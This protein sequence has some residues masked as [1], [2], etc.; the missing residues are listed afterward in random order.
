M[1]MISACAC[2][3]DSTYGNSHAVNNSRFMPGQV[4]AFHSP[5][6]DTTNGTLTILHVDFDTK[7]GPI[8][9]VSVPVTGVRYKTPGSPMYLFFS[10]QALI[11]S[12]TMLVYSNVPLT[13]KDFEESKAYYEFV[14]KDI[15]AGKLEKCFKVSVAEVLENLR[16]QNN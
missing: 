6:N 5:P 12:V 4:W 9:Y 3:R 7:E 16:K 10:E 2:R 11:G 1:I 14:H 8:L 13:G 15:E